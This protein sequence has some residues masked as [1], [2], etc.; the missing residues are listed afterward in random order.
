VAIILGIAALSQMKKNPDLA[1]GHG[2][3]WTGI[4]TGGLSVVIH[5][6]LLIFYLIMIGVGAAGH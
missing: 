3:A 6:A 2:Q 5:G 1:G 4:I